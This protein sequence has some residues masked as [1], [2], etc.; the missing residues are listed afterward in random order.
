MKKI[1]SSI[2]VFSFYAV[3]MLA[4][5]TTVSISADFSKWE[6]YP[7]VKKIG[8]YQTP[9][10]TRS[11]ISRDMGK[12]AE[13][14]VRSYRYEF[15]WGKDLY[16]SSDI[17]GTPN[18]LKYNW[19]NAKYMFNKVSPHSPAI[20]FCH[21]YTPLPLRNGTD[22]L[23]WQKPPIDHNLWKE[24]NS[25]AA[26]TWRETGYSNRYI[27][28]WNEPDLPNGFFQGTVDDYIKIYHYG[29]LGS[30]NGDPDSKV[31]GPGGAFDWWHEPLVN[32]CIANNIPLDFLSGHCYGE[33]FTWQLNT[34]RNNLNRLGNRNA[35]MLI[36]EY[37]PYPSD[38]Y[39]ANGPVERAEAAMTFF[40]AV[41]T[42]LQYTDLT[43]LTW[44]Q[45]I[46][47]QAGTSG[48][49][50][51]DWDKLGLIDGNYGFRKALFNAFKIYGMMPVDRCWVSVP[52]SSQLGTLASASDDCT[53]LVVWNPTESYYNI[54]TTLLK[55]P[56]K[57]GRLQVYNVDT[58]EN[59]WYET[60]DDRLVPS[61]DCDTTSNSVSNMVLKGLTIRPKGLL[62]IRFQA[63]DAKPLFTNNHF[64]DV[65]R[66]DHWYESTRDNN[67]P[68]AYFD[69]KTWT[70]Y[71]SLCGK[72]DGTALVSATAE[73]LPE[74]IMVKSKST[75][76]TRN[77]VNTQ[78]AMRIDFQNKSGQYVSSVLFHGGKYNENYPITL[79]WGTKKS[80]TKVVN[81]GNIKDF[82]FKLSDYA[83][84]TFSGRAIITFILSQTG[85]N[86]KCNFQLMNGDELVLDNVRADN[87][88]F[89][90]MDVSVKMDGN[91]SSLKKAGFIS[92]SSNDPL[93]NNAKIVEAEVDGNT[94]ST[95]L[96]GLT[97]NKPYQIRG[98]AILNSGDT[99]YTPVAI[100]QTPAKPSNIILN[101]VDCDTVARTAVLKANIKSSSTEVYKRGFVW[102]KESDNPMP[103]FSNNV[104]TMST[105]GTGI[106]TANLSGLEPYT[107]Y[108]VRAYTFSA[109]GTTFSDVKR[110]STNPVTTAIDFPNVDKQTQISA[111]FDMSGR[112]VSDMNDD[113]IYI[114][115]YDDGS[116]KK[117]IINQIGH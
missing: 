49:A 20:I 71:L 46:D 28:I 14:E 41:P 13:L 59:S 47:P 67:N 30:K 84:S 1:L 33:D 77:N 100:Y 18:D 10:I 68:Y 8:L 3:N 27:E 25:E 69:S 62:F 55:I 63:K 57:E 11:W 43:H 52:P 81:V 111:I 78:Q 66:T 15:A 16:T 113:G 29:A 95:T 44:A 24:V 98:V 31:G 103:D 58:T 38:Q 65:V 72:A 12:M 92:N 90:I 94:F 76:F 56:F 9:L 5:S 114:I 104:I 87:V 74:N 99:L 96:K 86:T 51:S 108:V 110:F 83:P 85:A 36:T 105:A 93:T 40:R 21:G 116:T 17:T 6:E 91:L 112:Q 22:G 82:S 70:A 79:S 50:Y 109:A 48:K 32:Y 53:A 60:G 88:K 106:F 101:E 37:S 97:A 42:I 34:M 4:Q 80:P 89:N 54:N 19:A 26:K 115:R 75:S 39:Q 117:V 2:I 102:S 35:E 61:V 107:V 7:L 45:Y 23:A 73:N 64:A